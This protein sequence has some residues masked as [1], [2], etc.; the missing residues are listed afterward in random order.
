MVIEEGQTSMRSVQKAVDMIPR[1]K[2]IG[3]VINRQKMSSSKD[4][5]SYYYR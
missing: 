3:F 4:Y 5:Y 1:E 2:F